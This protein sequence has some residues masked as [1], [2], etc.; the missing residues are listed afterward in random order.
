MYLRWIAVILAPVVAAA[1]TLGSGC[2]NTGAANPFGHDAGADAGDSGTG[3]TGGALPGDAGPDVDLTLGGPCLDDAQCDDNLDCTFDTCDQTLGRC[4]NVPDDSKCQ[5]G[6]YCNGMEV[7]QPR[8]GCLAGAPITCDDQN[9][10]TIDSCVESTQ[11]CQHAPR[12]AD[13]DGD[14]D[15]HCPNGHDCDDNDPTVSSLLPEVCANGKDDNCNGVVDETPCVSPMNSTCLDPL[16]INTSGTYSMNTTGAPFS[17]PTSCGLGS[18]MPST[19]QVV[20][21]VLLPAGAPVDVEVTVTTNGVPVSVAIA[22]QCG[23]PATELACGAA[24]PKTNGGEIARARARALGNAAAATA[25]PVYVATQYGTTV[26]VDVQILPA[27]PAPTNQSCG[28]ALPLTVGVPVA[29]EILDEAQNVGTACTTQLGDLVYS[30]T[31]AAAADVDVYADSSD[32]TGAPVISLRDPECLLPTDEITCQSAATAHVHRQ[33][34]PAGT[35]Y[36]AISAT[37]PTQFDLSVDVS[38]PTT[39]DPDQSCT[40]AP[41]LVPNKTFPVALSTHE[42]D[43]NLGCLPG[44]VDAAYELDLAVASDVLVVE[45]IAQGD[46]GSVGLATPACTAADAL[47]CHADGTSPVRASRRNVPAGAYRVVAES[48]LGEDVQLTAF[49][50]AAVPPTLVPFANGCSEAFPI[51]ATGG[52]FQGNTANATAS[53]PTGCDNGGVSGN[54][55]P[56]QL[57]VLTLT[58][59]QRVVFDME[60]SGYNTILDIRQGPSCPGTEI[61]LAC[62]VGY[63]ASRSYLDLTLDAG[64]YYVQIDGYEGDKGPWYL[65]VRVVAP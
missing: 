33:A 45:R 37:A 56:D 21:A 39:P 48:L 59:A 61:P 16:A 64:T 26:S 9:E 52:F 12:D 10:C 17:Y 60:G 6:I 41:V 58:A 63:A 32:G 43:T 62:A 11:A 40:G 36:V 8:H 5:D 24:F 19:R 29:G 50:R 49:V 20:A 42:D 1:V 51:P 27:V 28:T 22:G 38:A 46:T 35:Y 55:A 53:F 2:G 47:V 31:L 23:D 13:G 4:R 44:A 65:D 25:Y 30:F 54:G 15:A 18:A 34:M 3:G 7:C 57:L 14:V